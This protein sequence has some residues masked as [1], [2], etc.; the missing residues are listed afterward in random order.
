MEYFTVLFYSNFRVY[1]AVPLQPVAADPPPS[2]V[3][4]HHLYTADTTYILQVVTIPSAAQFQR[5]PYTIQSEEYFTDP[6]RALDG[7]IPIRF[8]TP[9]NPRRK[10]FYNR[11]LI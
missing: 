5:T 11:K 8:R 4:L 7:G 3:S 2:K 6:F 10:V 1:F 9:F